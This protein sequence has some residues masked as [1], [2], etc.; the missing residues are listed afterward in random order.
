MKNQEAKDALKNYIREFDITNFPGEKVPTA[1]LCLKAV[2]RALGD[3]DL[4]SNTIPKV[5]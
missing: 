3:D 4:P 5:L 2:A 1:C